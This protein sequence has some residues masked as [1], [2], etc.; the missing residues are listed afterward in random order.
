MRKSNLNFT[1]VSGAPEGRGKQRVSEL[2]AAK[3]LLSHTNLPRRKQKWLPGSEGSV[4]MDVRR[5]LRED[6]PGSKERKEKEA[7]RFLSNIQAKELAAEQAEV[8]RGHAAGAPGHESS[9]QLLQHF[10]ETIY[11]YPFFNRGE[12]LA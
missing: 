5:A 3:N 1:L 12:C 7:P 6:T 9:E 4:E 11:F 2:A 8:S 10:P